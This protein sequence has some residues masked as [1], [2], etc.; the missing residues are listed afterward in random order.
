MN[1]FTYFK[2]VAARL[3]SLQEQTSI[4]Q[5]QLAVARRNLAELQGENERLRTENAKLQGMDQDLSQFVEN[6][7]VLWKRVPD[8]FESMPYCKECPSHPIMKPLLRT[9]LLV[10]FS[11]RHYARFD[12]R[13]PTFHPEHTKA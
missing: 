4:L 3:A 9:R 2:K 7:G 5:V 13:P 6:M 11:G 1:P 8:G 10:C 12:A